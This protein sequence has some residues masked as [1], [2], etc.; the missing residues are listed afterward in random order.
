MY[1]LCFWYFQVLSVEEGSVITIKYAD[2]IS[3]RLLL[4]YMRSGSSM[5]SPVN[6]IEVLNVILW[7]AAACRQVHRE[8]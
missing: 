1:E 5:E 6:A 7:N 3:M 2:Q 8:F 4:D